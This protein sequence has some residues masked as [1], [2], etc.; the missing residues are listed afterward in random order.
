AGWV[1]IHSRTDPAENIFDYQPWH[2]DGMPEGVRVLEWRRQGHRLVARLDGIDDRT[3][4]EAIAGVS[5]SIDRGQLPEPEPGS[6]YWRDLIGLRIVNL[7]GEDLGRVTGL[8]DAGAHDVLVAERS[9]SGSEVLIPFVLEKVVKS[10]DLP[11]G[12]IVVD[13][14]S[15]WV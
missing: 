2:A 10:V 14:D 8:L 15:S 6:W 12:R 4:A 5:L 11:S 1:R 9:E 13:W 3:A 7:Q